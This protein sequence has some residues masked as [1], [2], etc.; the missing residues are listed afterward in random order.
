M[1]YF[2]SGKIKG[3]LTETVRFYRVDFVS[4]FLIKIKNVTCN[5]SYE[6][7]FDSMQD[8]NTLTTKKFVKV[9]VYLRESLAD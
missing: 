3:A 7:Y 8:S 2:V 4:C 6:Y 1:P 9:F 5:K